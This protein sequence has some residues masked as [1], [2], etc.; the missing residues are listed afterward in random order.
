MI[1]AIAAALFYMSVLASFTIKNKETYD[2]SNARL[3]A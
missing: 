2:V 1:S 3:I